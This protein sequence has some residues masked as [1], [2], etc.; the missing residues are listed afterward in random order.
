M[1]D[2]PQPFLEP[3]DRDVSGQCP[4]VLVRQQPAGLVAGLREL[5][6]LPA[7]AGRPADGEVEPIVAVEGPFDRRTHGRR[8]RLPADLAQRPIS[9]AGH[10]QVAAGVG[11]G[12][13]PF[14]LEQL[15]AGLLEH[16][17]PPV[18]V[19]VHLGVEP[20]F[21]EWRPAAGQPRDRVEELARYSQVVV[22]GPV[23]PQP[24]QAAFPDR[25]VAAERLGVQ[26]CAADGPRVTLGDDGPVRRSVAARPQL[27]DGCFEARRDR[28]EPDEPVELVL[29]DG[30]DR[31]HTDDGSI[32][33][34]A[35]RPFAPSLIIAAVTPDR[36]HVPAH[37][38]EWR[39]RGDRFA[40]SEPRHR[41]TKRARSRTIHTGHSGA[42]D[43]RVEG[44]TST[45][46]AAGY[47]V[48]GQPT[49]AAP[50]DWRDPTTE[51]APQ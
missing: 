27:T 11:P 20:A 18:E 4:V 16:V 9:E 42:D 8:V 15:K 7:P 37:R 22:V 12:E 21:D 24:G 6:H 33:P 31:Q 40:A 50:V 26:R 2:G 45:G 36:R 32:R 35:D 3:P 1:D 49:Y 51:G 14:L 46:S 38:A 5:H 47:G 39:R 43:H 19:G 34:H 25:L 23:E 17:T 13:S 41:T 28:V 29:A 48:G 44:S 30:T 10:W